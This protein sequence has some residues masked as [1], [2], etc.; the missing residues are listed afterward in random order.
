MPY[1]DNKAEAREVLYQLEKIDTNNILYAEDF[2]C[3]DCP[4]RMSTA[5]LTDT[6]MYVVYDSRTIIFKLDTRKANDSNVHY[7]DD[8]FYLAFK[9]NNG[10]IRGFPIRYEYSTVATGLNDILY[11]KY[12]KTQLMYAQEGKQGPKMIYNDLT[13]DDL[14]DKS[15]YTK[16]V[17]GEQ[18]IY[19]DKTLLSKM[20]IR[21]SNNI[22]K[23]H[24]IN[25]PISENESVQQ[26]K[27]K[28]K[29]SEYMSLN[30]QDT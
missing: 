10:T 9:M 14:F 11:H 24:I 2:I 28:S 4:R 26:L 8:K 17:R 1:E 19:T 21:K 22:K 15:S 5:I 18:S 6:H 3:P 23:T 20:T 27:P 13:M 30:V 29:T 16:T 12:H 25:N 7:M